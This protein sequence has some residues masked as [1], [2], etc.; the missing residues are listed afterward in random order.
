MPDSVRP[1]DVAGKTFKP[2][3]RGYD[4]GA[5]DEFLKKVSSTLTALQS[6]NDR[7]LDRL[8]K[9]G[10][11]DM[12]AEFERVSEE[13]ASLLRSARE[14]AEGIRS[15]AAVDAEQI[16]G[17]A[18]EDATRLRQDAWNDGVAMLDAAQ[19]E[20]DGIIDEAKRSALVVISEAER[21]AHRISGKA[22]KDAEEASR[23][24]RLQ[25]EQIL[26]EARAR[27]DGLVGEGEAEVASAKERVA[28]LRKRRDELLE[29][30]DS[31]QSKIGD[32]RSELEDRRAA[33]GKARAS[34]SASVRVLPTHPSEEQPTP[35]QPDKV[36]PWQEGE[37]TVR[38]VPPPRRPKV[39]SGEIDADAMAAEV[40]KLRV[41]DRKSAPADTPPDAAPGPSDLVD[42]ASAATTP[43]TVDEP[44]AGTPAEPEPASEPGE[45][46]E[47]EETPFPERPVAIDD[48]FA[49]LRAGGPKRAEPEPSG[50]EEPASEPSAGQPVAHRLAE[51]PAGPDPFELRERLLLPITNKTLRVVK[52]NLTEAQNI[53]LDE[54]RVQEDAWKPDVT[55]LEEMLAGDLDELLH[56]SVSVGWEAATRM[57]GHDVQELDVHIDGSAAHELAASIDAGVRKALE[58]VGDGPRRRA[59]A[60]SRVYRAWRVD[61]AERRVRLL[62]LGGYHDGLLGAFR[63]A[64]VPAVRW[65]PAGRPCVTCRAMVESGPIEPGELFAG[66]VRRPP[67]HASCECTIV[68]A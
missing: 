15:R 16:T 23:R 31:L 51:A 53:A 58:G 36:E 26:V 48:L 60:I 22:R 41:P 14:T 17:E 49:S 46:S 59:A 32:L 21:D 10:D 37:E 67:A 54:L 50:A 11:R 66:E 8:R 39:P 52:R 3:W 68:P 28:V 40:R 7:L 27:R 4:Q 63:Q 6:E 44:S 13:L 2:G 43:P 61:E 35:P 19:V 56:R 25:A 62:A 29:Q 1:E 38:I 18:V 47:T 57:L 42:S 45:A 5:V 65:V 24:A 9:L 33:I 20:A 55:A 30:V 64:G 12:H 34:D